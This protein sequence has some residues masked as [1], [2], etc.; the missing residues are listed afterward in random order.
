[1][2][3]LDIKGGAKG[4]SNASMLRKQYDIV[5][6][7]RAKLADFQHLLNAGYSVDIIRSVIASIAKLPE[8]RRPGS[9]AMIKRFSVWL[10]HAAE[11]LQGYKITEKAVLLANEVADKAE[12]I[13]PEYIQNTLDVYSEFLS[14]LKF[15][16]DFGKMV[17]TLLPPPEEFAVYWYS[18]ICGKFSPGYRKFRLD[19]A[20]FADYGR[21]I[22]KGVV[23][24]S[25]IRW[26][27][28]VKGI[29]K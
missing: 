28:L 23:A 19:H 13:P 27:E 18:K 21:R 7:G 17:W 24:D 16:D 6:P 12:P 5:V 9:T 25:R 4:R 8:D 29:G 10:Q 2:S 14:K 22:L 15:G 20:G 26:E 3:L 1:M 11:T